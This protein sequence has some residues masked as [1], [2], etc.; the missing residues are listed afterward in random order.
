VNPPSFGSLIGICVPASLV[1]NTNPHPFTLAQTYLF[2]MSTSSSHLA[3]PRTRCR[4]DQNG[5]A[6]VAAGCITTRRSQT[7]QSAIS[8]MPVLGMDWVAPSQAEDTGRSLSNKHHKTKTLVYLWLP[9]TT[10]TYIHHVVVHFREQHG[11]ATHWRAV[12]PLFVLTR[13]HNTSGN[14]DAR[15]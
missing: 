10:T 15:G 4:P 13:R 6:T 14:G 11:H 1:T 7:R 9:T 2:M 8:F 5:T 12:L 3:Y